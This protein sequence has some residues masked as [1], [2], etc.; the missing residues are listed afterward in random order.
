MNVDLRSATPFLALSVV[1]FLAAAALGAAR[2]P[3]S[4]A[5]PMIR[6]GIAVAVDG[7]IKVESETGL[8]IFDAR[9]DALLLDSDGPAELEVVR[10]GDGV[11]VSIPAG[12]TLTA[13]TSVR[14]EASGEAPVT[15]DELPYRGSIEVFAV[16]TAGLNVV[17][18]LPLEDYLLGVVPI[19]IGPRGGAELAAVAA[20]AVAARTYAVAHLRA[21]EVMGFDVFGSVQ[22]QAY[23]GMAAERPESTRAVRETTGRILMYEG[24]PIRAMYHSTCGGR[25][26]P[27]EEVL[28][29]APAAYLRS[30]SDRAPDGSDYCAASPRYRWVDTLRAAD[31]NGRVRRQVERIFGATATQTGDIVGLRVASRTPSGRV[32]A[33]ALRGT[34]SEF[35]LERLD[36]RVALQNDAGRILGSTDFEVVTATDGS[37]QLHGKGFGHGSGMCQWGAIGRARAGQRWETILETYYPGAELVSV[38]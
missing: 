36:I 29:R 21:R 11:R 18:Q 37:I 4:T 15:L 1:T 22:D 17:N 12:P 13:A 23:G 33:L 5:G 26:S 8:G 28:D 35:V 20:Q 38:Y 6:V 2:G 19:E 30:V 24:L 16:E 9:T 10:E 3:E 7:P 34:R 31:L 25:T 14:F 27:V 32:E